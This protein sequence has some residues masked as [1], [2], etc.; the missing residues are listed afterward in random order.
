MNLKAFLQISIAVLIILA[1]LGFS[2]ETAD[3][4]AY[5]LYAIILPS[6]IF[7]GIIGSVIEGFGGDSL[8]NISFNFEIYNVNF[9]ITAFALAVGVIKF[10]ILN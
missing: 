1:L 9:S 7:S 3:K 10:L 4:V 8:K 2:G 5:L 6:I